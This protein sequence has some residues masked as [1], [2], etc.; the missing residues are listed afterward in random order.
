MNKPLIS[1]ASVALVSVLARTGCSGSKSSDSSGSDSNAGSSSEPSAEAITEAAA[2]PDL[3]GTWKQTNS[4][5]DDAYQ[6]AVIT[7]DTIT[8]NWVSDGGDTESIYWVG[9]FTPP[10]DDASACTW[11]ST[12][13]AAATDSAMLASTD[14]A[15]DCTFEEG[16]VSYKASAMGTTT[17]VRLEKA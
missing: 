10:P 12:R 15:K 17:T 7:G 8:V 3:A 4:G 14:D 13:D 6:A 9:T 5:S 11:T 1:L 16:E 2:A